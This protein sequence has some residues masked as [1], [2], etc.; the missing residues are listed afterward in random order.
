MSSRLPA[1][2]I[3]SARKREPLA[4]WLGTWLGCGLSPLAPGT[5]GALGALPLYFALRPFGPWAV[6]GAAALLTV[7]GLWASGRVARATGTTDPQIVVIDE[8]AGVML[9]LVF[10][11]PTWA[12]AALAFG[13]FR[14]FDITKPPPCRWAERALAPGPG[15]M[16]DD[17]FA[18]MWGGAVILVAR[19]LGWIG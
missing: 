3:G 8:A 7:A 6:A 10:A 12:G 13:L 18:G 5:V 9:T 17:I 2:V 15:I 1:G 11:P 4:F 14:L 16:L 19:H